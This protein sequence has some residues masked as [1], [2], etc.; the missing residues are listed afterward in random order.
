MARITAELLARLKSLPR[1]AWA[2]MSPR[3]RGALLVLLGAAGAVGVD[4]YTRPATLESFHE[5]DAYLNAPGD[6]TV[7]DTTFGL[8]LPKTSSNQL[9]Q[10]GVSGAFNGVYSDTTWGA[11]GGTGLAHAVMNMNGA[12]ASG[13]FTDCAWRAAPNGSTPSWMR[14]GIR[15]FDID[16][17]VLEHCAFS[18]GMGAGIQIALR[19]WETGA[20]QLFWQG[21]VHRFER[22]TFHRIGNPKSERW[23][24]FTIS[25]HAPE[26]FGQ[27]IAPIEVQ[28]I[29]CTMTGGHLEWN[30]GKGNVVRSPRGLLVQGRKRLI[31]R[32]LRMDYPAPYDG[33][34]AQIWDV[35]DGDPATV[36]VIF[37]DCFIREGRVELRNCGTALVKN[38]TGGAYLVVGTN[39]K[40]D[41]SPFPIE[42]VT[43]Q[44]PVTA[45]YLTPATVTE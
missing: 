43:F 32:G 30:D 4:R 14:W 42:K 25:E 27:D 8:P 37:E 26:G 5:H 6:V 21:G 12:V 1:D 34:A 9:S 44:G 40:N 20:P 24:A 3:T 39:P 10:W 7:R 35:D 17:L 2:K 23:G 13:T 36:D 38:V 22:L 16:G 19:A 33:W 41:P 28:V 45:G 15:G 18:G 31:V 11:W 29:D